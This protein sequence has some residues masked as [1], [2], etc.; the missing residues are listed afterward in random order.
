MKL[1]FKSGVIA[2]FLSFFFSLPA[3]AFTLTSWN[4]LLGGIAPVPQGEHF[5]ADPTTDHKSFLTSFQGKSNVSL[6]SG[7]LNYQL[8]IWTPEGRLGIMPQLGLNYSSSDTRFAGLA[9]YGWSVPEYAIYRTPRSGYDKMYE[10]NEYFGVQLP[11]SGQGIMI[12]DAANGLYRSMTE[13]DGMSY[14]F[15]EVNNRWTVRDAS[16]MTYT[17]G[18][19][20]AYRQSDPEDAGRTFKWMLERVEDLNGNFMTF[21]YQFDGNK[22]YPNTIRYTGHGADAG[23]FEVRFVLEDR[24]QAYSDYKTAFRVSHGRQIDQIDLYSYESGSPEL[25]MSYHLSYSPVN[26]A[27]TLLESVQ[28]E[29]D[30]VFLP[31]THFDYYDGREEGSGKK[32]HG[33]KTIHEPYGALRHFTYQPSAAFRESD[34]TS[35]NWLPFTTHTLR[36]ESVQVTE[37]EPL[38]TTTYDYRDGHYYYD[39]LDAYRREYAGFGQVRVIDPLG[40]HQLLYFHQSENDPNNAENALMG[41]YEDYITKRGQVYRQQLFEGESELLQETITRWNQV[42]LAQ[43][44]SPEPRFQVFQDSVVSLSHGSSGLRARAS[45]QVVDVYGN[46]LEETDHGEVS[47][48]SNDG[49]FTDLGTDA[50]TTTYEYASNATNHLYNALM[51][52]Q[53]T[54]FD[55]VVVGEMH[56]YFDELPYG[57]V[58]IGNWTEQEYLVEVGEPVVSLQRAY[59]GFGLPIEST[60]ARGFTST[61][62]YDAFD[63]NPALLTNAKGHVNEIE[64]DPFFKVWTSKTDAN[65]HTQTQVLD[66]FGRLTEVYREDS[67]G[68]L[69]LAETTQYDLEVYPVMTTKTNYAG[70]RD[71]NGLPIE[72][73]SRSFYD[74][75]SREI[76]T[77]VEAEGDNYVVSSQVY[78]E[79]SEVSE[80][81]LPQFTT[82]FDYEAVN[83]ADPST[84]FAYDGVGRLISEE[85][86]LGI[87]TIAYDGWSKSVFDLNGHQ[88]D[89]DSDAFG[90]LIQVTEYLEGSSFD[91]S[92]GYNSNNDLVYMFDAEGNE[93]EIT[94]D[95]L[96]RRTTQT[97]L[98]DP[99]QVSPAMLVYE[100][101]ANGNVLSQTD[102]LGQEIVYTYD[103]LDRLLAEEAT[104]STIKYIYDSPDAS[105]SIGRLSAIG[106]DAFR[107]YFDYDLLG[108]TISEGR[109]ISPGD[110][111]TTRYEYDGIDG[112][113]S[114]I[115]YPNDIKVNYIYNNAGQ[116]EEVDDYVNDI[117]YAPHGGMS[118]MAYAN[119]YSTTNTYDPEQLWRLDQRL[120]TGPNGNIQNIAYEYDA[121]GNI[122]EIDDD[123]ENDASR[124]AVYEYDDLDRLLSATVTETANVDDYVRSYTYGPTGN[125]LSKSNVGAYSYDSLHPQAVSSVAGVDYD[126]DLNGQLIETGSSEF[127]YDARGDMRLASTDAGETQYAYDESGTRLSKVFDN[128]DWVIYVN[129]LYEVSRTDGDLESRAYIY[130]GPTKVATLRNED[131]IFFH[132][133]DHLSGSNVSTDKGG[134]IVELNDYFPYGESRIEFSNDFENNY[135]FTGQEKDD[136]S[137]LYY[138][139]ARYYD[140]EIGRFTSVDPW[141]GDVNDPQTL[142]KY[143]YV[144]NNPLK[145][146]DPTGEALQSI[147]AVLGVF[148]AWVGGGAAV[149][150]GV[151]GVSDHLTGQQSGW[152]D[153]AGAAAGGA[154][155]GAVSALSPGLGLAVVG[156]GLAGA[157]ATTLPPSLRGEDVTVADLAQGSFIGAVTGALP[158]PSGVAGGATS[159][160]KQITTKLNRGLINNVSIGTA[161][162]MFVGVTSIEVGSS[163][164]DEGL[165]FGA[166]LYNQSS[167]DSD[168]TIGSWS[169]S[170]DVNESSSSNDVQIGNSNNDENY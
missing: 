102:A 170:S 150:I 3:H 16:G 147:P 56:A 97:L 93:R 132:H 15:D 37:D 83:S 155:Q 131:S 10:Q 105:N 89:F 70:F 166:N 117:D 28:L 123:S 68:V 135:L 21:T 137:G 36:T 64:W 42:E 25:R 165:N 164:L 46:L 167:S 91:T 75:L 124:L 125:M 104:D 139:G 79:R 92:Y 106:S 41:E 107:K 26:A 136:E 78:N 152:E 66:G 1:I 130:A 108:R 90:R 12:S 53:K 113:L 86:D 27:I 30:G 9:G 33:L 99:S 169:L 52:S 116:L 51:H 8:P 38:Y 101:D 119:G 94:Y 84:L 168:V 138:Y 20:A 103:E 50:H 154:I 58:S 14:F 76:Q 156:G 34:T 120:T 85:N 24:S 32:L 59:N 4:P 48:V 55:G 69:T 161:G 88:K 62:G 29:A 157:T 22:V 129:D 126:Y 11:G 19:S 5:N 77:K 98:H 63:L 158:A 13:G 162:K 141:E 18:S 144:N 142:N 6:F 72:I 74:G 54:D 134:D 160:T 57:Q 31:E 140:S 111:Y 45:E 122:L 81:Y 60:N 23:L 146:N 82:S 44:D 95:L 112:S 127:V 65:G 128:D 148:A 2:I 71:N 153:Y 151:Q 163:A 35:S 115:Y 118:F 43:L 109:K 17:L 39:D 149:G 145:Y 114:R 47:L 143:T 159:L 133:D 67:A 40:N 96:G 87:S 61:I 7:V 100:Y 80:V 121:V 49:T 110:F 73:R